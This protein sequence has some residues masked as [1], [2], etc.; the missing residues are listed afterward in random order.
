M[1]SLHPP[2]PRDNYGL[3]YALFVVPIIKGIQEQQ[4]LIKS[5]QKENQTLI[6]Q[7]Q[8]LEMRLNNLETRVAKLILDNPDIKSNQTVVHSKH[9]TYAIESTE[10]KILPYQSS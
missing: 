5:I 9:K 2:N 1:V 8:A 3:S 7:N 6:S 4:H 10:V